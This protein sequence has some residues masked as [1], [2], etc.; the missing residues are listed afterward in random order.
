MSQL[1]GKTAIV[2]GAGRGIG[3]CIALRLAAEGVRV[4]GVARKRQELEALAAECPAPGF[5]L[6]VPADISRPDEVRTAV[7]KVRRELGP[8]DILVNNAG[9]F[10]DRPISE[11]DAGEFMRLY[12]TNVV[13]AVVMTQCALPD[14]LARKWGRIVNLCS[15][16][17]HRG[18]KGQSAYVASKHALLGFSKVLAEETRGKGIRVHA[19]SPGGVNTTMVEGRADIVREDYM[20]PDEIARFIVFLISLEGIATTDEIVI[21]RDKAEPF[22]LS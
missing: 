8:V 2:T 17:S 5:I 15:T 22:R 9:I 13:G 10:L 3:R 19:V 21:R 6:P 7:D 1:K 12:Q 20:D 16:A 11:T 4:A 18:Y 14:M